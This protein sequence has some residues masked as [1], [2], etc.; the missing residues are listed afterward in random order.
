MDKQLPVQLVKDVE[1]ALGVDTSKVN[2]NGFTRKPVKCPL[3]GHE[4]DDKSPAAHWHTSKHFL[5]CFKC[6][7]DYNTHQVAEALGIDPGSYY[8]SPVP[9]MKVEQAKPSIADTKR[10]YEGLEDYARAHG[11]TVEELAAWHWRECEYKRRPALFFPTPTGNRWRF[12]DGRKPY[13]ISEDG[14]KRCWFGLNKIFVGN[15]LRDGRPLVIC[16]GEISV[17]KAQYSGIAAVAMTGGEKGEIPADLLQQLKGAIPAGTQIIIAMDCD[18]AGRRS[19]RGLREQL[20]REGFKV[21]AVDMG[22]GNGGD[23]ADFCIEHGS[24][25]GAELEKLPDLED[26]LDIKDRSW[27]AEGVKQ[28]M[29]S[30]PIDWLIPR[31]IPLRLVT[32]VFGPSGTYKS[33]F[34]LHHSLVVAQRHHVIYIAAEGESGYRQRLEAWFKH[35]QGMY[36][37]NMTFILGAIDITND[38][39]LHVFTQIVERSKPK[40][41]VIDTM[42]RSIGL[43]DTNKP[44]DMVQVYNVCTALATKYNCAIVIVHHTNAE[45]RRAT[46]SERIKDSTDMMIRLTRVD[47]VI[48]VECKKAKDASVFKPFHLKEVQIPLGYTNNLGEQVTSLVLEPAERVVRDDLTELQ[49]GVL[50]EAAL[51]PSLSYSEMADVLETSRNSIA[52]AIR[53]VTRKG[54]LVRTNNGLELTPSGERVLDQFESDSLDSPSPSALGNFEKTDSRES[55]ESDSTAVND[56][57]YQPALFNGAG[58]QNHNQYQNQQGKY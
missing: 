22:L 56:T 23:L 31:L 47:D 41:I 50:R 7:A 54:Y 8:D 4:Q 38:D 52:S 19:A 39:D 9:G 2:S 35:H 37:E 58:K 1:S 53:K 36:T 15:Q 42:S 25:T 48:E 40:M 17:I 24:N 57:T 18:N 5:H 29:K 28:V 14:Y 3:S 12:L 44:V 13:Y 49:A 11:L 45:G 32:T 55:P 34:T 21:R 43:K 33:F 6:D 51:E 46:G 26:E 20:Q 16:N 30:P 27:R 10:R